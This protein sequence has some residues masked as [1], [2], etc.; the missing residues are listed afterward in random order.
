MSRISA[1]VYLII[2]M[3]II[4]IL[5]IKND[6]SKRS[7]HTKQGMYKYEHKAGGKSGGESEGLLPIFF[8]MG[9]IPWARMY[10]KRFLYLGVKR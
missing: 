5:L 10:G 8:L 1:F 6:N 9:K 3:I 7:T 4:M 2:I